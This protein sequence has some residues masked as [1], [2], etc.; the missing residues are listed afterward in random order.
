MTMK[1]FFLTAALMVASLSLASAKTYDF[2]LSSAS[3]AGPVKLAAGHY[4]LKVNGSVAEFTNMDT[5]KKVMVEVKVN[6]V[7]EKVERTQVNLLD[8]SGT[9]RITSIELQDSG[10]KLEF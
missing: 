10:S 4:N 2:V 8:D 1:S 3:Q 5:T 7:G 6:N 9:Q